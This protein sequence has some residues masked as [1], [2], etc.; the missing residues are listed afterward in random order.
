[1][2]NSKFYLLLL[3]F[4]G[5]FASLQAQSTSQTL[6][7]EV[8][9]TQ[10]IYLGK[11]KAIREVIPV[12]SQSRERRKQS[13]LRKKVPSN[14]AG[15][16][17][18]VSS[19]PDALPKGDDAI[20]QKELNKN[21]PFPVDPLVNVEGLSNNFGSPHDP[22]GD[23]GKDN[24]LQAINATQLGVFDKEGNL[25]STFAAN[26]IWSQVG[27]SSAGDPIILYDQEAERWLI[28]EFPN[29]N[30]LL[31]AIS[32]DSDPMG[33]YTA[34]NFATPNF[35]D[36][37]KYGIWSNAYV[38]TTNENGPGTLP[39]Y[40]IDRDAILAGSP[41]VNIQRI[42]IPGFPGGPGFQVSTP[43]DWSGMT[44]P[45]DDN[46]IILNLHDDAFG[47]TPND[48][49]ILTTFDID[50]DD[51][52][53]STAITTNIGLTPFD[54]NP[55]SVAG[56]GFSCVPQ[57]GNGGGLDGLPEV[58][59][60]QVHY[61][62][63]GSHEAIVMSFITDVTAGDNLSGIRWTEL[64]RVSGGEWEVFQE[65]TFAPD[66]GLD[67]YMPAIAM[68]GSGNIGLAYNCSSEN[69]FV[70]VRYTGRR[71]SDPLGEMTVDE[72]IAVTG[73]NTINSG[74]RFGDYSQMGIDP[75]NDRT[76]WFTGEYGGGGGSLS[77]T[78][79]VAFEL[80]RDTTDIGPT[81]LLTPQTSPDLTDAETVQIEVKNFGL[82]TQSVFQVGYIFENGTAVVEDVD[83]E[84]FPDSIYIHTF[85]PTVDMNTI[86]DYEFKIF[87]A[88][89][90]DDAPLNDTLRVVVTKLPR[91]DAG[92]LNIA[93]LDGSNCDSVLTA[94]LQLT[95]FGTETLTNVTIT[96]N[97]NGNLFQ[98]IDWTGSLASGDSEMVNVTLTGFDNGTNTV[99]ATTSLPNDEADETPTN[100][101]FER[102]FDVIL[103][104]VTVTL[105]LL[106]D[107][108]PNETTWEVTD[109][110]NT[111]LFT[112]GPYAQNQAQTE[113]AVDFCLDPDACYTF[114]IMDS[115]G[116]GIQAYGITGNYQIVDAD[117][118][119]LASILDVDFGVEE[120]NDFCATFMCM[121]E[122]DIDF[123]PE[124]VVGAA[125]GTIMLTPINGVGPF[126]YSIDGGLNFQN[127]NLFSN[128]GAGDYDIIITGDADC[129]FA[130]NF[131]LPSCALNIFV[132][133][134]NTTGPGNNDGTIVLELTGGTGEI[135]YS[136]DGG[137]T[138]QNSPIFNN[139]EMGTYN[140][141]I[142]DENGCSI[143]GEVEVDFDVST[144]EFSIG[145][146]VKVYPN[147][148][149]GVF[150][151][152]MK[153]LNITGPY[154]NWKIFNA[155]GKFIYAGSL[156]K[157]DDTFTG[158]LSLK[159]DP[160]G[161]YFVK[162]EGKE[163]NQMVRI[164]KK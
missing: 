31:V 145:Q 8:Q 62:N 43:V 140:I 153:G 113:I 114:T 112:G 91:F 30:Q 66:D 83:F 5:T 120:T 133:V 96:V 11:T 85:V 164:L 58:I 6:D 161:V 37:P 119:V 23:I 10:A 138:F 155:E 60:N 12:P 67:R 13:K 21:L 7:I 14:F 124:T 132:E 50:F 68:D 160:A 105:E 134:T 127:S 54:S 3:L 146:S 9:S 131:T 39:N 126:Q 63:F 139:L 117:G 64:R 116:D 93:G 156:V 57:A 78:R 102:E 104:G 84:L 42:T 87:T 19:N 94:A 51:A 36:Y 17:K 69:E 34:Y 129:E 150:R 115:F 65:G 122:A 25:L 95:N 15:R 118:N 79:I 77:T 158:L 73:T 55:C 108:F 135:Q 29:G 143:Q 2:N 157:Y 100:D 136:I 147:P 26:T 80:R 74:G 46:P 81:A 24:Y 141:L 149:D 45:A 41:T 101:S 107:G 49:V 89:A 61:R 97:L 163:L 92:I 86:A 106:F 70:G 20:W 56:F 144:D 35:P 142:E 128:L 121:L 1:M 47:G 88:L 111:V 99:N 32:E 125:D 110:N 123:S 159:P 71:A 52:N 154:L 162:F 38:V 72:F 137:Q 98:T 151:I 103:G 76:F 82:D 16:G 152:E 130:D 59:M 22:S 48:E 53:N 44:Q 33:T 75:T 18:Y 148:T 28:T 27:F 90:E 4:C 109:E 40:F